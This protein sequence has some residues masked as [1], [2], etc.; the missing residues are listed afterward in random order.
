[1]QAVVN[2]VHVLLCQGKW[3]EKSAL[4]MLLC[5]LATEEDK[6][7]PCETLAEL[8]EIE[9]KDGYAKEP[10]HNIIRVPLDFYFS[11]FSDSPELATS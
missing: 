6:I 1:M 8:Q 3:C 5:Q 4:S 11:V 2:S 9:E 7:H 10:W